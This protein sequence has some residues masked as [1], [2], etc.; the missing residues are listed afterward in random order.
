M[1][2]SDRYNVLTLQKLLGGFKDLS[3]KI[4]KDKQQLE[5]EDRKQE[6]IERDFYNWLNYDLPLIKY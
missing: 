3:L 4:I 6:L 1:F 2:I 5:I